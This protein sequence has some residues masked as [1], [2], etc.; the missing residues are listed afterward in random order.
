[1][2]SSGCK[3]SKS[4]NLPFGQA[5]V[6]IYQVYKVYRIR[7]VDMLFKTYKTISYPL[8]ISVFNDGC[9]KTSSDFFVFP[10]F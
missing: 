6:S 4:Y 8:S 5:V 10:G 3:E 2:W 9:I 1:M 7:W